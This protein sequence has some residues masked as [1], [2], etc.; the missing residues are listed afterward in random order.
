[1][2]R[3][4]VL[5]LLG[6]SITAACVIGPKQ[7][8]PA[9]ELAADD[10]GTTDDG[11]FSMDTSTGTVTDTGTSDNVDALSGGGDTA[12]TEDAVATDGDASDAD[13]AADGDASDASDAPASDAADASD[14]MEGG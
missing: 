9:S 2:R 1:M 14:A 13:A 12:K 8:D 5:L 11:A 7:D 6:T 10:A 4:F 3:L